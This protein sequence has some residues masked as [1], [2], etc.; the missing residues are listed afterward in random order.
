[1][2][3]GCKADNMHLLHLHTGEEIPSLPAKGRPQ[4]T[5]WVTSALR[6]KTVP[7]KSAAKSFKLNRPGHHCTS[8][9]IV[10]VSVVSGAAVK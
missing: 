7:N 2:R 5:S 8:A 10:T 1:M 4:R 3:R 9:L 6:A